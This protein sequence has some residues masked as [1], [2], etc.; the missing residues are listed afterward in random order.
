MVLAF[1]MI[2]TSENDRFGMHVPARCVIRQWIAFILL[3]NYNITRIH[4][5]R[6]K[7]RAQHCNNSSLAVDLSIVATS[8]DTS[9]ENCYSI[10][11]DVICS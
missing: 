11:D 10:I 9:I 2:T 6:L 8:N 4:H 3:I 7:C 5:S 1:L